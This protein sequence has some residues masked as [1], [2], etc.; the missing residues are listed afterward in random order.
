MGN[1]AVT[2][3]MASADDLEELFE[4]TD[5]EGAPED[6]DEDDDEYDGDE[7]D[8]DEGDGARPEDMPHP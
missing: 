3:E 2:E 4:L 1:V 8:D 7:E 6:D 5:S